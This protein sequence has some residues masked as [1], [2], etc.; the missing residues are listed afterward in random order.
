M[1]NHLTMNTHGSIMMELF[2]FLI[3][4]LL[5]SATVLFLVQSGILQV[6]AV[7]DEASILNMEFIPVG[8]EGILAMKEF[9]FCGQ[10][11]EQ[12]QCLDPKETFMIREEVHFRFVVETSTFNGEVMLVE[13][14]K[15]K[16]PSGE[17]LLDVD[18]NRNLHYEHQSTQ[19]NEQIYFKDYLIT[20]FGDQ[21]G[22]YTFELLLENPLL[23]KKVVLTRKFSLTEHKETF[24]EEDGGE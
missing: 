20:E 2:I 13:N 5:T 22:E 3:V 12:Y 10:V 23:T 24:A 19:K 16:S 7:G 14:Y 17:V 15:L 4:I 11:N 8:R 18:V 21:T 1:G 6:R 9:Q